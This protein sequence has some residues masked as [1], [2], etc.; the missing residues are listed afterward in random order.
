[1]NL[2]SILFLII[3]ILIIYIYCYFIFPT[4]IIILQT[5]ISDFNFNILTTGT[6][7]GIGLYLYESFRSLKYN[8]DKKYKKDRKIIVATNAA[9][10]SLTIDGIKVRFVLKY[11]AFFLSIFTVNL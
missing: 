3:I 9:E 6:S 4:S 2:N 1:M 5:T 10:S 8:R 7:S 11:L